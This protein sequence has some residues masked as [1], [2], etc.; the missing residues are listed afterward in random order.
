M[1][2]QGA[3]V[4]RGVVTGVATGVAAGA[5]TGVA[6]GVGTNWGAGRVGGAGSGMVG[7]ERESASDERGLVRLR[8]EPRFSHQGKLMAMADGTRF[9]LDAIGPTGVQS[10]VSPE[11]D[12]P[13]AQSA[14]LDAVLN[15]PLSPLA[16]EKFAAFGGQPETFTTFLALK[17][18]GALVGESA[19]PLVE[20]A[21]DKRLASAPRYHFFADPAAIAADT[22]CTGVALVGLFQAGAITRRVLR[23]GAEEILKS[24]AA[25]S[26]P[27][28][29]NRAYGKNNGEL[30]EGVFKVYW[31]DGV[32]DGRRGRKHDPA[33]VANALHAVL[34]AAR[35][36]KLRLK[37]TVQVEE[38]RDDGT[39]VVKELD[40]GVIVARNVQ[41]LMRCLDRGVLATGTRYYPSPDAFLCFASMLVT[42]FPDQTTCLR[43]PLL[44]A[45]SMRWHQPP[46]RIAH[47]ADPCT[48]INL[49]MRISAAQNLGVRENAIQ[50]ETAH[51]VHMQR[52]NGAWPAAALFKLGSLRYYFGSDAMTTMFA[53]RA[54]LGPYGGPG[55]SERSFHRLHARPIRRAPR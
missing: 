19:R 38:L 14:R 13:A 52:S 26:L 35:H 7:R 30:I 34:L 53:L 39:R 49:A 22:D 48:A 46:A 6:A 11:P 31:D 41:Y 16:R 18:F 4:A 36:A 25:E 32:Q 33:C 8:S 20:W 44:E 28:E 29:Q 47:P 23:E 3:I 5:A 1:N 37:G 21:R 2:R 9:L 15:G 12:F 42:A 54:L 43:G 51:L 45:L 55:G 40:R 50:R 27:A 10:W 17:L 24:A